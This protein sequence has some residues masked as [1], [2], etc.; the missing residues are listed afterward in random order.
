MTEFFDEVPT[1]RV[2]VL[3][4]GEPGACGLGAAV[5][6]GYARTFRRLDQNHDGFVEGLEAKV[7]FETSAA[8][9]AQELA[10]IW[11]L[12]DSE[13][14]GRLDL[15]E[16]ACAAHLVE[17][18]GRGEELPAELPSGLLQAAA[19]LAAEDQTV[20][21]PISGG[22]PWEI[23]SEEMERYC[24]MFASLDAQGFG[25]VSV[26]DS[27]EVLERTGLQAAELWQIWQL[28]QNEDARVNA[29][30]FACALHLAWRRQ[31]G[32][33]LPPAL[34]PELG[35]IITQVQ[36]VPRSVRQL[37]S[38][39]PPGVPESFVKALDKKAS[40][41]ENYRSLWV[42][43]PEQ[44]AEYRRA[45]AGAAL[46]QRHALAADEA[47]ELLLGSL[48]PTQE[49]ATV[50][51]LAD[52][53]QDGKLTFGEFVVAMQLVHARRQGAELPEEVPPELS[54]LASV[55][56]ATSEF[57]EASKELSP[58]IVAPAKLAAYRALF[59]D[60]SAGRAGGVGV[61][62]P[63]EA[64]AVLERSGL[65]QEELVEI[66]R[67]ADVDE[68]MQLT[69]GE[70]V[71]AMHLVDQRRQGQDLP[72]TL[73]PELA[74]LPA[75]VATLA[76][77]A[78]GDEA[79]ASPWAISPEHLAKYQV[80]FESAEREDPGHLGPAE[81]RELLARSELPQAELLHI[82]RLSDRD[83]DDRL[84][85]GEFACAMH[86]ACRRR[87]GVSLPESL[88]PELESL[89]AMA[90]AV[91]ALPP[92]PPA[93][94]ISPEQLGRYWALFDGLERRDS[95]FLAADE[96]KELLERSGLPREELAEIWFLADVDN[97]R[98]LAFCEFAC[99]MHLAAGRRQGRELPR[100]LP[101]ELN[102][103]LESHKRQ[104]YLA[105]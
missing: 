47:R 104:A 75:M 93:W 27:R 30:G 65:P 89:A 67:M 60:E 74:S 9:C 18:C 85:L 54:A 87:Q 39:T 22:S 15:C 29:G 3:D 8:L 36:A 26:E 94:A 96:V 78:P 12:C 55:A 32:F 64:K 48:L 35:L 90:A 19:S 86:L 46:K 81:A 25:S 103:F 11:T 99:A 66:W 14:K 10:H 101:P 38:L 102:A 63:Q 84:S 80:L 70:F 105:Q 37:A 17:L 2:G 24:C 68:D 49:L 33:A 45:F 61:M 100:E 41:E 6:A 50:W 7:H 79:S 44:L 62:G 95:D 69:F 77:A 21:L 56:A 73:P 42:A 51:T 98:R 92:E 52:A 34:P 13:R 1:P 57:V 59:E 28:V 53:D 58:W 97:D 71:C 82:W 23:S 16:F 4:L 40:N 72:R 76:A 5:F 91:S 88:P 31:K 20:T 43:T 83:G